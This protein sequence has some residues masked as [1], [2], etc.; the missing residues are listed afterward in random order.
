[1]SHNSICLLPNKLDLS[2]C[3]G[4]ASA[5]VLAIVRAPFF[6]SFSSIRFI[7]GNKMHKSTEHMT[8]IS[9]VLQTR[10]SC[11][12]VLYWCI[13][14]KF[15]LLQHVCASSRPLVTHTRHVVHTFGLDLSIFL[16]ELTSEHT[17]I[18]LMHIVADRILQLRLMAWHLCCKQHFA[19]R[20]TYTQV[21]NIHSCDFIPKA[22]LRANNNSSNNQ[23][24]QQPTMTTIESW[25]FCSNLLVVVY[26]IYL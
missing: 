2:L 21:L 18:T 16:M 26:A 1:M 24:Q 3:P 25:C 11:R 19:L 5:G 22:N 7:I 17:C 12:A 10:A 20:S 14:W 13:N 4:I 6:P 9:P 23:Q 15:Q 8:I